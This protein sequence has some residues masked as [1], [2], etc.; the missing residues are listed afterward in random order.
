MKRKERAELSVKK[1]WAEAE[2]RERSW[3]SLSRKM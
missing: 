3:R 2:K 1:V